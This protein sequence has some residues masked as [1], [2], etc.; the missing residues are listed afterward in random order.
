MVTNNGKIVFTYDEAI[1]KCGI[2]SNDTFTKAIDKLVEVG[3]I[4]ISHQGGSNDESLY[5]ISDRWMKY[6]QRQL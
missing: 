1:E 6:D 2:N 3:F 4:D 5:A